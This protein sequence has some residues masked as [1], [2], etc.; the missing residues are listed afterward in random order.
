MQK[1]YGNVYVYIQSL[2]SHVNV[3]L[4]EDNK[5][6]TYIIKGDECEFVI[7]FSKDD[8]EPRVELQLT[9]PNNDEYLII[10]EFYDFQNNEKEKDE[11]FKIVKAVLSNSIKITQ[12]LYKNKLIKTTYQHGYFI[13]GQVKYI[14]ETFN[15]RFLFPWKTGAVVKS[16][17]CESW[18]VSDFTLQNDEASGDN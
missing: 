11:I 14:T 2:A 16:F 3:L 17:H 8:N 10:G 5:Y 9:C 4:K 7:V 15:N 13:D 6:E 18:I 12:F 1:I